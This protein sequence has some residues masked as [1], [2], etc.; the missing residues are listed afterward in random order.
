MVSIKR[1]RKLNKIFNLTKSYLYQLL[2]LSQRLSSFYILYEM[3]KLDTM[4]T[5]PFYPIV[6]ETIQNTQNS[7]EKKLLTEF[8]NTMT[9]ET[10]KLSV[11]NFIEQ[12]KNQ[13]N[14]KINEINQYW[15]IHD[16]ER[17]KVN[18]NIIIHN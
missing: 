15:Q 11:K 13:E 9:R 5:T 18:T 1:Q 17:E 8:I 12:N 14:Y 7:V 6:L 3:Y 2:N 16:K 4:K 10:P